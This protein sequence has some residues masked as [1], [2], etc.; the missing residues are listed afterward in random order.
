LISHIM[1]EIGNEPSKTYQSLGHL[2]M[3][4][5]YQKRISVTKL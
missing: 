5:A 1:W 3:P 2:E 4:V